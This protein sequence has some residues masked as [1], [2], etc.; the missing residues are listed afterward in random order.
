M[1][2]RNVN[3]PQERNPAVRNGRTGVFTPRRKGLPHMR[4]KAL[5]LLAAALSLGASGARA[6]FVD[7]SYHWSISPSSVLI[8]TNPNTGSG[9]SSGSVSFALVPDGAAAALAGGGPSTIPAA[10]VT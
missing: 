7:F 9:L 6:D 8:G 10:A 3:D 1:R 5:C 2:E 4:R